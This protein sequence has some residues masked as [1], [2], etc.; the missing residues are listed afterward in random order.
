MLEEVHNV[1]IHI[2][3]IAVLRKLCGYV[4]NCILLVIIKQF[5]YRLLRKDKE[6]NDLINKPSQAKAVRFFCESGKD[7]HACSNKNINIL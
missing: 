3:T 7:F 6:Y 4:F 2:Y 5:N 1:I